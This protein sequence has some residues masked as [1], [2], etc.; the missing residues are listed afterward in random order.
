VTK[1]GPAVEAVAPG[2]EVIGVAH[3]RASH[4]KYLVVPAQ[5]LTA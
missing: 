5:N 4:A 2:Y 1:T 3:E